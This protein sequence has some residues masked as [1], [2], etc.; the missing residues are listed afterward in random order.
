MHKT[1]QA[2][3]LLL[4]C[5]SAISA[6]TP[7][8]VA[9]LAD[10]SEWALQIPLTESQRQSLS[11][12]LENLASTSR[13]DKDAD[14][15]DATA[16]FQREPLRPALLSDLNQAGLGAWVEQVRAQ[17]GEVV[18]SGAPPL[19]GQALQAL[20]EWLDFAVDPEH[21]PLPSP[22]LEDTLRQSLLVQYPQM[23]PND[24]QSLAE[25]PERWAALR[26]QW[27]TYSE[28]KRQQLL[29]GWRARLRPLLR[30]QDKI[31][32][33]L[34]SLEACRQELQTTSSLGDSISK[35]LQALS[36]SLRQEKDDRCTQLADQIDGLFLNLDPGDLQQDSLDQINQTLA[37]A[38]RRSH[39]SASDPQ[40][41]RPMFQYRGG[42]F[43]GGDGG[44]PYR[45]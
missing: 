25:L 33:A 19:T 38:E 9:R 37:E 10:L 42:I 39:L 23:S 7:S 13:L 28:A 8:R 20:A 15:L 31:K 16:P 35:R 32:L 40:S 6:Q 44:R 30:R 36:A 29:D 27:P 43:V 21:S 18:I 24:Q 14:L 12:L 22:A 11:P 2:L 45:F 34:A 26:K 17:A 41:L 5:S 4:F 1:K 3:I